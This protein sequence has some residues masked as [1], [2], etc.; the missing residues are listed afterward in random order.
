MENNVLN[1]ELNMMEDV[2]ND[3][4]KI[5]SLDEFKRFCC[6]PL[7]DLCRKLAFE[8][9]RLLNSGQAYLAEMY[10][11]Q[12]ISVFKVID[13]IK[14]SS[15]KSIEDLLDA[16]DYELFNRLEDC[17][18]NRLSRMSDLAYSAKVGYDKAF[19]ILVSE[20]LIH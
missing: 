1:N 4:D 16:Y 2:A 5:E 3:S 7:H 12:R 15:N 11:V 17:Q 19:E 20:G 9:E 10:A 6:A 8:E 14:S 13:I 18:R